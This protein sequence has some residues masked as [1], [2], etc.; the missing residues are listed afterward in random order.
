MST[1]M[2][3][4]LFFFLNHW[5]ICLQILFILFI[6]WTCVCTC[7][8]ILDSLNNQKRVWE[9]TWER[10][11]DTF[12]RP[13]RWK[14]RLRYMIGDVTSSLGSFHSKWENGAYLVSDTL[15]LKLMQRIIRVSMFTAE[16]ER[17]IW[18]KTQERTLKNARKN[19]KKCIYICLTTSCK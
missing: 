13:S 3:A 10:T 18:N 17:Q 19:I 2:T 16:N 9:Y 5:K 6:L 14:S 4:D 15:C 8:H 7:F 11:T 12:I 1:K